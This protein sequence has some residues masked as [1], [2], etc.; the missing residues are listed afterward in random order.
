MKPRRILIAGITGFLGSRLARALVCQESN[1][2]SGLCRTSSSFDQLADSRSHVALHDMDRQPLETLFAENRF[3]ILIN[4]M[5]NYGKGANTADVVIANLYRPL[6]L[7]EL[8]AD[9]HCPVFLNAGTS[10]PSQL[11]AY[12]FAKQ[13]FSRTMQQ[14]SKQLVVIDAKLEHFYGAGEDPDRFISFI[15]QQ[16]LEPAASLELTKGE[17]QR[18]F[19]HIDDVVS[20]LTVLIEQSTRW[21]TGYHE[22]PVG[23]GQA[24]L[25]RDVV[26]TVR[27]LCQNNT[28]EIQYGAVPYREHEVMYSRAETTRL[29]ELGWEPKQDLTAGLKQMVARYQSRAIQKQIA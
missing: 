17:Q 15:I 16:L 20:A 25:L 14:A 29:R 3:D 23:S 24:Y 19:L 10:L 8:C 5:A 6:K 28:T 27:Q 21:E 13:E 26:E 18:D 7:F 4:C 22:V 1:Q 9:Y 11:N 2:V 12:A